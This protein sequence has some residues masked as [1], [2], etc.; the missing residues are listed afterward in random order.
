MA[1]LRDTWTVTEHGVVQ[2]MAYAQTYFP[3]TPGI[4][5]ARRV[6]VEAGQRASNINFALV[7]GRTATISGM[8]SDSAGRPIAGRNVGLIQELVGPSGGLL[9]MSGNAS[10]GT[11]GTFAIKNVAP[12]QYKLRVQ[13]LSDLPGQRVPG[14]EIASVPISVDGVDIT[15]LSL[16]T[17]A[18]W[19]VSGVVV[20]ENGTA[21]DAPRRDQFRVAARSIDGDST[22]GPPPPPPAP[23]G[24]PIGD[25]G[26]VKDDW[27]FSVA[28]V[29]GAARLVAMV[30]DGW[31]VKTIIHDG[32][33]VIDT[34]LEKKSGEELSGVQIVVVNRATRVTGQ[35]VDTKGAPLQD[36]T[37]IVFADDAAKWREDSRWVRAVR[38][39]QQGMYEIR[40]LPPGD[41]L[42]TAVEYVEDGLWNDPEYLESLRQSA[43][44]LTLGD[45]ESQ[46]IALKLGTAR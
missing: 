13:T 41:Y 36:G 12:G 22:P 20:T 28:N 46:S 23:G 31:T 32:R 39:D 17:S 8:A 15:D 3:G 6:T 30:P 37:I 34:P 4:T 40:G 26:R 25:S 2:T 10:T 44:K 43:K 14:Q 24:P 42:A 29:F 21:P 9:M 16:V 38:P 19:S 11:D 1:T 45:G 27:T 35:L 5:D 33:D 18:G 7:P